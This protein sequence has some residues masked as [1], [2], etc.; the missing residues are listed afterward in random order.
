[1][2]PLALGPLNLYAYNGD[3]VLRLYAGWRAI[4]YEKLRLSNLPRY[5]FLHYLSVPLFSLLRH[6]YDMNDYL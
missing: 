2:V 5:Q 3:R 4:P 1:M 6:C